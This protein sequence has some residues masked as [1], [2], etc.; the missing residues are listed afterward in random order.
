MSI[1]NL[2]PQ[3]LRKAANLKEKIV[4]LQKQLAQFQ[5]IKAASVPSSKPV[6]R[7]FSAA[8]IARIKAAQRIRWAK[9]KAG[10]LDDGNTTGPKF[11]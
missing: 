3:Q 9:I 6:R 5:E 2:T 11:R 7:K 1:T 4:K 10:K 8:G